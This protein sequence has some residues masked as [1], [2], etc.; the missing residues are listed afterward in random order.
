MGSW[1][2]NGATAA[3]KATKCCDDWESG[4]KRPSTFGD[5]YLGVTNMSESA[6]LDP[7]PPRRVLVVDDNVDAATG[8]GMLLQICGHDVCVVHQGREVLDA[9]LAHDAEVVFLDIGLPD[10]DGY[11]VV[12]ILRGHPRC[13]GLRLIALS[14]FAADQDKRRAMA[15][16]FN[17]HLTKPAD[18]RA[19][20]AALLS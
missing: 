9:T 12:R 15:A 20:Q 13:Q 6:E 1:T 4:Q 7:S 8:I 3:S 10:M 2:G 11:E 17:E 5:D 19:I 14:G 16:G 18:L